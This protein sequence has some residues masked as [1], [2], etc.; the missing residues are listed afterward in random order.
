M[1][2]SEA[3]RKIQEQS[4]IT[5]QYK[6]AKVVGISQ[7][8]ISNYLNDKTY[9]TLEVAARIYKNYGLRVEPYTEWAILEEIKLQE[10]ISR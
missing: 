3:M 7:G 10:Q 9:P 8:T 6:L 2:I 5:D 4:G 1:L